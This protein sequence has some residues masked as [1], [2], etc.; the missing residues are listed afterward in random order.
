MKTLFLSFFLL[1]VSSGVY[2]QTAGGSV[3]GQIVDSLSQ[4]TIP[5]ATVRIFSEQQTATPVKA[6]ATDENGYFKFDLKAP[7]KYVLNVEYTGKNAVFKPFEI[8]E[9][10][11]LDCGKIA[12]SDN[13]QLL[14]EVTVTA[15]KALVKIDLDKIVYNMEEDTESKTNNLLEML[16]KVPMVT[17]D[18]EENIQLKGSSDFKFY[19]NG[20]PSNLLSSNPK[21]VLRSM[22]AHT[23]KDVEVITDPGAKYDAEGVTGI[24][25]IITKSQSA[26]GGYTVSLSAGGNSLG[27]L[28]GNTYFSLKY[29]KIGFTG[30]LGYNLFHQPPS[31]STSFR[32]NYNNSDNH[33]LTQNGQNKTKGDFLMGSGEF[34]YEIDTLNLLNVNIDRHGGNFDLHQSSFTFMENLNR[35]DVYQYNQTS[36]GAISQS[37]ITLGADYQR[38]FA[39]KNRLLTAS[40]K[41]DSYNNDQNFDSRI[42]PV[43]N[44]NEN[45]NRQFSFADSYEH[46]FQVDYTTPFAQIHT[47]EAGAKFIRRINKSHSGLSLFLPDDDW[48]DIVSDNDLFRHIQNIWAAYAGYSIKYKQWGLKTGLRYEGTTLDANYP[49]HTDINFRGDYSNLIP[50]VTATHL[51]KQGQTLR[52][53]YNLRIQRPGISYLNPYVNT[54]DSNYIH[55]GN[56]KLDAVKYHNFNLNYNLYS[57]KF[58][59]NANLSYSF[60]NNGISEFSWIDDYISKASY[61]N[62]LKEHRWNVS[63]YLSWTPILQLRIFGNV[64]GMYNQLQS[65]RESSIR[66]HGFS[67]NFYAGAQYSLPKEFVISLNGFSSTPSVSLQGQGM[68]YFYYNLSAAKSFLNK[69]LNIRLSAANI[70]HS[71]L[72]FKQT[73]ESD[74]FY[75]RSESSRRMQQISLSVSYSFGEMKAQIKK[76]QRTIQNDDQ[77]QNA[78]SESSTGDNRPTTN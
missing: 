1:I 46:T 63:S 21:E 73:R 33:F 78:S 39:V 49:L 6:D 50:S 7:G 15:Q 13:I 54:T 77:M 37:G 28:F 22:P 42:D 35:E 48:S 36:D 26:L 27:A 9:K 55:F 19:M 68:S 64:S 58:T 62:L 70:F 11:D 23:V 45:R 66:N 51:L 32:E 57:L 52:A 40:Y 74:D 71:N 20:K 31:T 69:R 2:A 72:N 44:F 41:L 4:E 65:N 8:E 17:V 38:S 24:I 59:M 47:W 18:G 76:A 60:S 43:L 3:R 29:G 61:F 75:Y 67:G 14:K 25:N 34:S 12:L 30:N 56:P 5:F 10:Q 53:G 16:K